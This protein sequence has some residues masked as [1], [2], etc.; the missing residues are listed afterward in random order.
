MITEKTPVFPNNVVDLLNTRLNL[1]DDDLRIFRRPLRETDP[2]QS[3]GIF[4]MQWMPQDDS[5]EF[6]GFPSASQPTIQSY[7]IMLQAFIR[8]ADEERGLA[9]HSVLTKTIRSILYGDEPLQVGLS[10]LVISMN[11]SSEHSKRWGIR[12]SRYFSNEL[13]GDWIYLST[14]EFWLETETE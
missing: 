9:T 3:I 1:I 2:V 12:Q 7:L 6:R 14:T 4:A 5:Y 10:S 11:G 13:D 8:D